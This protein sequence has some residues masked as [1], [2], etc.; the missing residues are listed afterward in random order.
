MVRAGTLAELQ[1]GDDAASS[2]AVVSAGR[3][4]GRVRPRGPEQL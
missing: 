4:P 3:A 2:S 1:L